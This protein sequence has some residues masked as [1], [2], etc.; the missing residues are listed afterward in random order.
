M[1]PKVMSLNKLLRHMF[2]FA[3]SD[4]ALSGITSVG[5]GRRRVGDEGWATKVWRI[6]V[7]STTVRR[8]RY[9]PPGKGPTDGGAADLVGAKGITI[10]LML[11]S[12]SVPCPRLPGPCSASH[13]E[14]EMFNQNRSMGREAYSVKCEVMAA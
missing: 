6:G 1:A 14:P 13:I 5:C 7:V 11:C 9:Q 3:L 8:A 4:M 2:V 12:A 10:V